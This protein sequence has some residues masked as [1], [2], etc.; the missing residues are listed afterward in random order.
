MDEASL[1]PSAPEERRVLDAAMEAGHILLQNGAEIARVEETM[2]R[3][4]EYYGVDTGEFFVLDRKS[5][6]LNSSH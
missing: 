6:R 4:C 1:K 5:T 2:Q 3:I